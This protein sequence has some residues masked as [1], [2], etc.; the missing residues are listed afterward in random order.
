MSAAKLSVIF[1]FQVPIIGAPIK[2]A[3]LPTG[4][5]M[6]VLGSVLSAIPESVYVAGPFP[7]G[8][9]IPGTPL[10]GKIGVA[11]ELKQ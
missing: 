2:A 4:L 3:K 7:F 5:Y 11:V 10:V 9:V 8:K 6:F 1:N